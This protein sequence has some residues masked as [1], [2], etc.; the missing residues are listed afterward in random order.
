MSRRHLKQR[1][2]A[3]MQPFATLCGSNLL[4]INAL[5]VLALVALTAR[6]GSPQI[7]RWTTANGVPVYYVHAPEIPMFDLRVVFAAGSARDGA[8]PGIASLTSA[9]L[10]ED[11]AD[12]AVDDFNAALEATG[13]S[14]G[15][16]SLR[17]MAWLS[18]RSL[19]DPKAA[20]PAVE[21]MRAALLSPRFSDEVFVRTRK[22]MLAGIKSEEGSPG[23]LGAKAL[24]R[25]IYGEHPYAAPTSGTETT[26]GA[27]TVAD[28]KSFYQRYYV[29]KNAV[30]IVVGALDRAMAEKMTNAL[31]SNLPG[32]EAPPP[33]PAVKALATP[34]AVQIE[35]PAEQ[36]HLMLGQPGIARQDPDYFPLVVGNHVLGGNGT[37][38]LLFGEI[39]EQRGLSYSVSSYFEPMAVAGPFVATLQTDRPR[40]EEARK[41]LH[42]VIKK[43]I[44][45]GPPS[46]ALAAAK[47]NLIG[48]FPL[49]IDNNSKITEY[50]TL[51][52]FYAL[53]LDYLTTYPQHVAAVTAAQIKD[54]F[55][56]RVH[57]ETMA[58]I[59][60]GTSA[61]P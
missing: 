39:R 30:L 6:A 54:A 45:D 50:I 8:Q 25:A 26:V 14:L 13:A 3:I 21:L 37:V 57:L 42:A 48:G 22:Q 29:A 12:L 53:P 1:H 40:Q 7:E 33:L 11:T 28:A 58:E 17:D 9:M 47:R 16:G 44:D 15:A 49:R 43:F 59:T 36:S 27:F 41:V 10:A 31:V 34:H 51:I 38:S 4:R 5:L 23:A 46:A 2:G 20:T 55:K 61:T 32:G 60:V 19:T 52:A 35:F 56:R 18:L 24:Y